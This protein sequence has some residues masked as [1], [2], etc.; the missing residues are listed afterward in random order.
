VPITYSIPASLRKGIVG[1]YQQI[2]TIE[3]DEHG[4]HSVPLPLGM[5]EKI[6]TGKKARKGEVEAGKQLKKLSLNQ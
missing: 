4:Q 2:K 5:R 6:G 1:I 3:G